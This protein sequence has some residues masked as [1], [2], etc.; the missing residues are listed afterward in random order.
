V[1]VS[2]GVDANVSVAALVSGNDAVGVPATV[3]GASGN[4]RAG[5]CERER[6]SR[7]VRAGTCER[8]RASGNV[9]AGTQVAEQ[10]G[11][12]GADRVHGH[13][14]LAVL[15]CHRCSRLHHPFCTGV[16]HRT[17]SRRRSRPTVSAPFPSAATATAI[18][19]DHA[20]AHVH[21]ITK[22]QRAVLRSGPSRRAAHREIAALPSRARGR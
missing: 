12:D 13:F 16:R 10:R 3:E 18:D 19:N 11:A 15:K 8:E 17:R 2:A 7:N 4:V 22:L 9:R 20:N 5:T 6:A 21:V 1:F 14:G